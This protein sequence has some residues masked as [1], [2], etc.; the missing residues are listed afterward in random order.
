MRDSA[1]H[2]VAYSFDNATDDPMLPHLTRVLR[3]LLAPSTSLVVGEGVETAVVLKSSPN[4]DP[5]A[6]AKAPIGVV[7]VMALLEWISG[8]VK[9]RVVRY[10]ITQAGRQALNKLL[11]QQE[12][13]ATGFAESQAGFL[14][15]T[16]TAYASKTRTP[17]PKARTAGTETP[18]R[19]LARKRGKDKPYLGADLVIAAERL[20]RDFALGQFDLGP[21]AAMSLIYFLVVLL[22]CWAFYTLMMR[23][24]EQ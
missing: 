18:V 21:A 16:G 4:G 2:E 22:I 17:R 11:A 7:E 6:V 19:V 23:G 13:L 8:D 12:T 9:G 15:G 20:N 14:V 24:E 5:A 1:K 3:A 10:Q